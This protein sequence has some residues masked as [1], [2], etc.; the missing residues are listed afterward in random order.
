[1]ASDFT[2]PN[3]TPSGMNASNMY[4]NNNVSVYQ[5]GMSV[6]P[7]QYN[8][9]GDVYPPKNSVYPAQNYNY[10]ARGAP[11]ESSPFISESMQQ[12]VPPQDSRYLFAPT[13]VSPATG[14]NGQK[15]V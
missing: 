6:P 13:P 8:H 11:Y 9:Y 5:E 7:Q 15:W 2:D 12:S 10:D 4:S 1:M 3:H 14:Q